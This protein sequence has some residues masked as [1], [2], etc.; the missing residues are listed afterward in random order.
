MVSVYSIDGCADTA[1]VTIE[2]SPSSS[3]Q[4]VD[5]FTPNGDGVNDTWV[6]DYLM[7]PNLPPYTLQIMS[8]GG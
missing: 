2:V 6:V 5:L 8:R 4:I 3:I 7:D 1:S